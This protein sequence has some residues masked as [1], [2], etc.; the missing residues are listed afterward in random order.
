MASERV[1]LHP[2]SILA[3]SC[4]VA[5]AGSHLASHP[6]FLYLSSV[7]THFQPSTPP[8]PLQIGPC[9][10]VVDLY[11]GKENGVQH[12]EVD[13][14]FVPSSRR[15]S[16]S[17]PQFPPSLAPQKYTVPLPVVAALGQGT[18]KLK[19]KEF[20]VCPVLGGAPLPQ[21]MRMLERI[22]YEL[23]KCSAAKMGVSDDIT[24]SK[25]RTAMI[26]EFSLPPH[27]QTL[28]QYSFVIAHPLTEGYE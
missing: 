15:A 25:G 16:L 17:A 24:S 3:V 28:E 5:R 11:D 6:L 2:S 13:P 21:Q 9:S 22:H 8:G 23:G 20:C 4:A 10:L 18:G 1:V 26:Y 27:P 14:H 7:H 12:L 19:V